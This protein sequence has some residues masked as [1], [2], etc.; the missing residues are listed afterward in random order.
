MARLLALVVLAVLAGLHCTAVAQVDD[1]SGFIG[2]RSYLAT[3][4]VKTKVVGC[5]SDNLADRLSL[6][7][8]EKADRR[9]LQIAFVRANSSDK[10]LV[11]E[12]TDRAYS[13]R[14][15]GAPQRGNLAPANMVLDL[16]LTV[17]VTNKGAGGID[18]RFGHHRGL[19][20]SSRRRLARLQAVGGVYAVESGVLSYSV[21]TPWVECPVYWTED[22]RL[23]DGRSYGADLSSRQSE[24][25]AIYAALDRVATVIVTQLHSSAV[26]SVPEL[27][28]TKD[29]A[30]PEKPAV[31]AKIPV[32]RANA[33]S[34]TE[35][36][37]RSE[38]QPATKPVKP[39]IE[40]VEPPADLDYFIDSVLP[41][42]KVVLAGRLAGVL[43][44]GDTLWFDIVP[45]EG[46]HLV[47]A[48]SD[49]QAEVVVRGVQ[50]GKV[51]G[52]VKTWMAEFLEPATYQA[53][54]K[55]RLTH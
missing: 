14:R 17:Q 29:L 39:T 55:V 50:G 23:R 52:H 4:L 32:E 20:Y 5:T 41:G 11:R 8:Q 47:G 27:D 3:M 40:Y 1:P 15:P 12:Y 33:E 21:S 42:R 24:Q 43:K 19:G 37:S 13:S 2:G 51:T 54:R 25:E 31:S 16:T 48:K 44:P 34:S 45:R 7:I 10:A 38:A 49:A 35:D 28:R 6:L 26:I 22:Y 18:I 46:V 30:F 53:P 36:R 9:G